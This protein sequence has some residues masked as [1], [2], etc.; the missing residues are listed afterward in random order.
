MRIP[1]TTCTTIPHI[2]RG[3]FRPTNLAV[4]EGFGSARPGPDVYVEV[5]PDAN[6]RAFD[7]PKRLDAD[8]RELQYL[9]GRAHNQI[10]DA[11]HTAMGQPCARTD[12]EIESVDGEVQHAASR[13]D[14]R[15]RR[16]RFTRM[17]RHGLA[18]EYRT[19]ACGLDHS[20]QRRCRAVEHDST[21]YRGADR[22]ACAPSRPAVGRTRCGREPPGT[23]GVRAST[24]AGGI[25]RRQ[26]PG[27][28]AWIAGTPRPVAARRGRPGLP[29]CRSP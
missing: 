26:R 15:A 12:A 9:G 8:E 20:A 16:Q 19:A 5:E 28:E 13:A 18:R 3:P 25:Q 11:H 23:R 22:S 14:N 29:R 7:L 17:S 4:P 10:P 21:R 2:P 27:S 6:K 24:A 1:T